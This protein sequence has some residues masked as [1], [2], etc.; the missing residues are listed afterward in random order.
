MSLTY[1]RLLNMLAVTSVAAYF[2]E[3]GMGME[4]DFRFLVFERLVATIFTIELFIQ[5]RRE[6]Q[7]YKTGEFVVDLLSILPFYAGFFVPA[8]HLGIVRTLRVFRLLK[9][10]W[11]NDSFTVMKNAF[12]LAWPSV[13]NVGFCLICLALFCSTILYQVEPATFGSIGNTL[14]FV[15]TTITTIGFGDFSPKTGLGKAITIFLLYGP[16]LMVCG[17]LIGVVCS[18]YQTSLE[19]FNKDKHESSN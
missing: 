6:H 11:H 2:L 12:V 3:V 8:Q 7:Y 15:L 17:S 1:K 9:L 18:S 19:K 4:G 14:Y 10:F 5:L 16:S 13:K